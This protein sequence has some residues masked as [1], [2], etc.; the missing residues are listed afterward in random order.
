MKSTFVLNMVKHIFLLFGAREEQTALDASLI[1]VY[2]E[3]YGW[4]DQEIVNNEQPLKRAKRVENLWK[5][6]NLEML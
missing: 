3:A 6:T 5:S 2:S 4:Q 1:I